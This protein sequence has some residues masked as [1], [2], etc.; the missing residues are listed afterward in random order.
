MRENLG[1]CFENGS[2][3]MGEARHVLVALE[4]VRAF[5]NSTSILSSKY[6]QIR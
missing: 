4:Q 5:R 3:T 2:W 6:I 1:A